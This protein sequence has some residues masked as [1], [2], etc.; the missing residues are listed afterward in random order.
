VTSSGFP[1]IETGKLVSKTP[2]IGFDVM[3]SEIASSTGTMIALRSVYRPSVV[4]LIG[5]RP[6]KFSLTDTVR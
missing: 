5:S 6:L 2:S 3:S 4:K 1:P